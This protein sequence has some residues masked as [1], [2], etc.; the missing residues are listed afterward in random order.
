MSSTSSEMEARNRVLERLDE[1]GAGGEL[2]PLNHESSISYHGSRMI[3][4]K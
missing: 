4:F 1:E 2:I 3:Q